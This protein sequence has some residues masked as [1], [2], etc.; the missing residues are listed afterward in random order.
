VRSRARAAPPRPGSPAR[1]ARRTR[2][3]RPG[4]R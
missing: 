1:A 4:C 3:R 2:T